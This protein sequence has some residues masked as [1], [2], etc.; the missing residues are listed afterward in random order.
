MGS[1]E[2]LVLCEECGH[3]KSKCCNPKYEWPIPGCR[4]SMCVA[5]GESVD[6]ERV[7]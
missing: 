2:P 3:E 7:G 4:C 5:V 6:A 1:R